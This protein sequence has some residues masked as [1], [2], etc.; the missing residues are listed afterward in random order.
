MSSSLLSKLFYSL[1]SGYKYGNSCVGKKYLAAVKFDNFWFPNFFLAFKDT[2]AFMKE[3]FRHE[4]VIS[5]PISMCISRN[6]NIRNC[7]YFENKDR[8]CNARV[9]LCCLPK[10]ERDLFFSLGVRVKKKLSIHIHPSI[11]AVRELTY[12]NLAKYFFHFELKP[13]NTVSCIIHEAFLLVPI[14]PCHQR[15]MLV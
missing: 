8:V 1:K 9:F 13:H 4:T 3:V 2:K 7:S 12:L 15:H 5:K 11:L 10:D 14:N 6:R